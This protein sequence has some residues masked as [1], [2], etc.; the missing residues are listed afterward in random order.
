MAMISDIPVRGSYDWRDIPARK[1]DHWIVGVDLGQSV[2]STAIAI[3][4]HTVTPDPDKWI[5]NARAKAW[6]Q[7]ST[8]RFDLVHLQRLPLGMSYVTQCQMVADILQREPLRSHNPDLVLDQSGVGAGICDLFDHAGLR[9]N[10]IVITSGLDVTQPGARLW[11]VAKQLLISRLEAAMHTNELH[12]AA[13]LKENDA[14]REELQNFQR[15]TSEAGR[16]SFSARTASTMTLF[17]LSQSVSFSVAIG[18]RS[19]ASL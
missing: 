13:A 5:A 11:H 17:L 15:R 10:R 12:V 9:P 18:P 8:Q 7:D 19:A 3:L 2:D 1:I 16:V 4:H 14:F 6:K